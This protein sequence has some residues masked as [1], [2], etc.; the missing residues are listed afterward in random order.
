MR[1]LTYQEVKCYIEKCGYE[2]ISKEYEGSDNVVVDDKVK[3]AL[4]VNHDEN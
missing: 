3:D 2:L 1:R 4:K